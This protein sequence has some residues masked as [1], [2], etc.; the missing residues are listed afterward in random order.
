MKRILF[1]VTIILSLP[2]YSQI[3]KPVKFFFSTDKTQVKVGDTLTLTLVGEV[4]KGFH[5]YGPSFPADGPIKATIALSKSDGLKAVGGLVC[6]NCI[7]KY[8][9]IFEGDVSYS[10]GN[11]V[12]IQKFVV[13]DANSC[14]LAGKVEGQACK[15]DG[16]CVKVGGD[17]S[18]NLDCGKTATGAEKKSPNQTQVQEKSTKEISFSPCGDD[19]SLWSYLLLAVSG[20]FLALLTPCVYPML[21]MTVTFFIKRSKN[22]RKAVFDALLYAF[23]IIF[24]YTVLGL[25]IAALFGPS[26]LNYLSTHW[27]PNLLFFVIFIL[28]G[29]SFLGLFE[30]TL[31]NSMINKVDQ[32]SEK[33]GLLGI[34]FMA[35]TLVLISFSCTGPIA[36]SLL[37]GAANGCF[38]KPALGMFAYSA[39]F[40]LPFAIFALFPNLLTSLPKSGSWLNTVKVSLGLIE[41]ALAFKFLSQADLVYHWDILPRNLFIAIHIAVF[42]TLG[43]YLFKVIKIGYEDE[44][45]KVGAIQAVFGIAAWV[46][47]LYL[48]PGMF[49]APLKALSGYLPPSHYQEFILYKNEESN[50]DNKN[51]SC[52]DKKYADILFGIE[53]VNGYLE[54]NQALQCAKDQ[55]KPLFIDFTG[56]GCAN[57]RR[58]EEYVFSKLDIKQLFKD[59]FV[60]VSLYVDDKT[61][62]PESEWITSAKDGTVYKTIG[63]VNTYL[64][65]SLLGANVQPHYV[66]MDPV[67]KNIRV[68]LP[69]YNSY[70]DF[71]AFLE[72]GL[73]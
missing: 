43:F 46:F 38:W 62:L 16:V 73:K 20:G 47:V 70:E 31:P 33:G 26:V 59:K 40:A 7:T 65:E 21:P 25:L 63:D 68:Q 45:K 23:F 44:T 64:Q 42:A 51:A 53:G 56:H 55:G 15:D 5:M 12:M 2:T 36:S 48:F 37:A 69:G 58:M 29:L 49:G 41:L 71:K 17:F 10:E 32:K 22:R 50:A 13:I 3:V 9:D 30:I 72:K 61:K 8:D 34:F 57:C 1:L 27:V 19:Q 11:I 67:T 66:I 28:F 6:K 35:F 60:V 18:F 39:T 54:Y 24:I 52:F 14:T 4:A